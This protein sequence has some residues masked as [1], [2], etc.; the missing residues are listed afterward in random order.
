MESTNLQQTWGLDGMG[1]WSSYTSTPSTTGGTGSSASETRGV[2]LSNQINS[3][4]GMVQ[5]TYDNDG[6]M[7]VMPD[8]SA[9]S[10]AA[11]D[12]KYDAWGRLTEVDNGAT[13]GP[14]A[15]YQYDGLGR[16]VVEATGFSSGDTTWNSASQYTH[17]YY[18]AG[19]VIETRV[20]GSATQAPAGVS[21]QYQYVWSAMSDAPI[22]R[23]TV[24]GS[25]EGQTF[26]YLTDAEGNVTTVTDSNGNPLERYV[27]DPYGNVTSYNATWAAPPTT[28]TGNTFLYGGM[29]YDAAT[30]LYYARARWYN[31]AVGQFTSPDPT[32]FAAGDA[33][34]Y[35]YVGDNPATM[36]DPWGLSGGGG[37]EDTGTWD[38]GYVSPLMPMPAPGTSNEGPMVNMLDSY[39]PGIMPFIVGPDAPPT[40]IANMLD[41]GYAPGIMPFIVDPDAPRTS[42]VSMLDAYTGPRLTADLR[43]SDLDGPPA[44]FVRMLDG[45][46]VPGAVYTS[47][48]GST[49][50]T[51]AN[52][53]VCH[54]VSYTCTVAPGV[55]QRIHAGAGASSCSPPTGFWSSIW[56]SVSSIGISFEAMAMA[57]SPW[58]TPGSYNR[59][60]LRAYELGPLGQTKNSSGVYYYGTRGALAVSTVSITLAMTFYAVGFSPWLGTAGIHG[61]HHGLG[62]H[63]ELIL[64]VGS[65][66]V[67]KV[68]A[69]ARDV[70]IWWGIR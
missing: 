37:G 46:A 33:N 27:Y 2:N 43:D 57:L 53:N 31:P 26:Y 69:P 40:R 11:L 49:W 55:A 58:S 32:G 36:T 16:L 35:R 66:S 15:M 70:L 25:N 52:G 10:T 41:S 29:M 7:T 17:Y 22:L 39:A 42:F 48:D 64:R 3:A 61:A 9:P 62:M 28:D 5:P 34:L 44:S 24:S 30:G 54:C 18:A 51:D 1:N 60:M 4:A 14:I 47:P 45:G 12:A 56:H 50:T 19:Q 21:A 23:E 63:F 6:N 20:T 67:L 65:H 68:I 38:P 13:G 8:P 59:L